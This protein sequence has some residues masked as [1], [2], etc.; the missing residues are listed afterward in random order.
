MKNITLLGALA[1][2]IAGF[3]GPAEAATV[4]GK[5]GVWGF[6]IEEKVI[7]VDCPKVGGCPVPVDTWIETERGFISVDE[8][9]VCWEK[10]ADLV[11]KA[12][13]GKYEPER[14]EVAEPEVKAEEA[15]QDEYMAQVAALLKVI[16]SLQA[17]I[18][19]LNNGV[20]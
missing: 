17:E 16:A 2:M 18:E 19:R 9:G 13:C 12:V 10:D 3:V 20:R 11:K 6:V 8:E 1:V 14:A 4:L 7:E 5:A 15:A